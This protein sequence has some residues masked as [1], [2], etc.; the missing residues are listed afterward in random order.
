MHRPTVAIAGGA[1]ALAALVAFAVSRDETEAAD[2]D[3]I[4]ADLDEDLRLH[5]IPRG[6]RSYYADLYGPSYGDDAR[7]ISDDELGMALVVS[8]KGG[9]DADDA[10]RLRRI[11]RKDGTFPRA[12]VVVHEGI[13]FVLYGGDGHGVVEVLLDALDD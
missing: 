1:V 10:P 7:Y 8:R 11:A 3:E 6:T 9:F 12:A 2:L 13:A 4:V 5:D